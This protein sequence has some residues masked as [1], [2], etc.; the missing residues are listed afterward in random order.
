MSIT[1]FVEKPGRFKFHP[2]EEYRRKPTAYKLL[3][4]RFMRFDPSRYV[5]VNEVGEFIVTDEQTLRRFTAH[6]LPPEDPA[7]LDLKAKHFLYD[8]NSSPLIDILSTKYRT[9]KSFLR[10]FTKLHLFVVTLRCDH[11][12]LYCQ[13][14]RQSENRAAYDMKPSTARR[15]VDMMLKSPAPNITMEFQGGESL[16]NFPLIQFMVEYSEARNKEIGKAIDRVIAT[17]LSKATPAILEYCRDHGIAI[18]TSLDGPEWL[19]NANRPRPGNDS[20]AKTIENIELARSIVGAPNVAALMTTT[21]RSLNHAREIIDEY[22]H[23]G[24]RSIF[25]RAISPYGF[26]IKTQKKT[27]YFTDEFLEF[28]REG[29]SYILDLNRR[30]IE[31]TEIY[32]KIL[33]TK[34]LTPFPTTFTDLQSPASLGIGAVV[35]NYDGDVYASDESRMLAEM[36]DKTFRLGNVHNDTYESIFQG[37]GLRSLIAVSVNE[38]LPGC[39]DCA[40]QSYCGADP[41]FHHA[42]QHDMIGHRSTSEFC[43]KN[44]A[45]ITDLLRYIDSGDEQ[46]LRTFWAWIYDRSVA[47]VPSCQVR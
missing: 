47:E 34:I 24:F 19:H 11:S 1:S 38:S 8:D 15:A 21:R 18:S 13:V 36:Q 9:K 4:F 10:G 3:P 29:L 5:L 2:L 17:N 16:L 28:Y 40:Y 42:T 27:G 7:Y 37:P 22:I 46:I 25:L 26:A 41:V 45:I 32:A 30:G 12:C 6:N 44:M 39:S 31:F 43:R 14:S 20:Y 35:Y 33:L 23:R